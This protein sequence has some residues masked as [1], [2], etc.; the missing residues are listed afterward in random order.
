MKNRPTIVYV[1]FTIFQDGNGEVEGIVEKEG[2]K[3]V[4]VG[5]RDRIWLYA[6]VLILYYERR[7]S[8]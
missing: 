7:V 1:L 6:E 2:Q 3:T 4:C 5:I 8:K